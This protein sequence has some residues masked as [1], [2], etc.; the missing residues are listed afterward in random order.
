M[1][2]LLAGLTL[3]LA[4]LFGGAIAACAPVGNTEVDNVE[5]LIG[6][7]GDVAD[8]TLDSKDA[9]EDARAA[10]NALHDADKT[11]VENVAVLEAAEAEYAILVEIDAIQP[12]ITS[13]VTMQTGGTY[14]PTLENYAYQDVQTSIEWTVGDVGNSGAKVRNG[15]ITAD[16]VG[17][18]TLVATVS[19]DGHN[20]ENQAAVS[21][22]VNGYALSGEVIFPAENGDLVDDVRVESL[23]GI[24]GTVDAEGNFEIG[25]PA[26]DTTLIFSAPAFEDVTVSVE[27]VNADRTISDVNFADYAFSTEIPF[28]AADGTRLNVSESSAQDCTVAIGRVD[29]N[30][31]GAAAFADAESTQVFMQAT[32]SNIQQGNEGNCFDIGLAPILSS[33]FSAAYELRQYYVTQSKSY[34]S[35]IASLQA[36]SGNDYYNWR[37]GWDAGL[38]DAGQ[39]KI[40][41][42]DTNGEWMGEK[43][44]TPSE[45]NVFPGITVTLTVVR[46]GNKIYLWTQLDGESSIYHGCDVLK[47]QYADLE[48]GFG[49]FSRAGT[50]ATFSDVKFST[51][52]EIVENYI[53][54]QVELDAKGTDYGIVTLT[55]AAGDSVTS[56]RLGEELTLTVTPSTAETG[57]INYIS[58][59]TLNNE[60]IRSLM[61]QEDDS[62]VYTFVVKDEEITI[63]AEIKQANL[64][65]VNGTVTVPEENENLL[66]GL[67]VTS[68]TGASAQLSAEGTFSMSVP[69]NISATLSVTVPGFDTVTL[70]KSFTSNDKTANFNIGT[71]KYAF[72]QWFLSWSAT[73]SVSNGSV[74]ANRHTADATNSYM[75]T[76]VTSDV[77]MIEATI[78]NI[79]TRDG[80]DE[81]TKAPF[82]H[83][84]V[85]LG[86][87][88]EDGGTKYILAYEARESGYIA[89]LCDPTNPW[90][91]LNGKDNPV[92]GISQ[93]GSAVSKPDSNG[94]FSGLTIKMRMVRDE[95]GDVYL[96]VD[97]TFLGKTEDAKQF[98]GTNAVSIGVFTRAGTG[99]TFLDIKF[100][101]DPEKV[102]SYTKGTV[103]LEAQTDD[104]ANG[105]VEL[106]ATSVTLGEEVTLTIKPAPNT[107][108]ELYA[109]TTLTVG[110]DNIDL[111]DCTPIEGGYTYT[112]T[113]TKNITVNVTISKTVKATVTGT[114]KYPADNQN[115][116]FEGTVSA[117]GVSSVAIDADGSF[118]IIVPT[119]TTQLVFTLPGFEKTHSVSL[120]EGTNSLGEIPLTTQDYAFEWGYISGAP[121][122]ENWSANGNSVT[123]AYKEADAH[124]GVVFKDLSA[125]DFMIEAKIS[126]ISQGY[127]DGTTQNSFDVGFTMLF[128]D[129]SFSV[130]LRQNG[131]V[132]QVLHRSNLYMWWNG[133]AAGEVLFGK[134]G[135]AQTPSEGVFSTEV[136]FRLARY[137]DVIYLWANDVFLG[138][139]NIGTAFSHEGNNHPGFADQAC[140]FGLYTRGGTPATFS[141]ISFSTD[142]SVVQEAIEGL[143]HITG[144]V[145]VPEQNENLLVS[146]QVKAA[147]A[148]GAS[149][150]VNIAAGGGYVIAVPETVTVTQLTISLPGFVNKTATVTDTSAETVTYTNADYS[151]RSSGACTWEYNGSTVTMKEETD[152]GVKAAYVTS[153]GMNGSNNLT[154]SVFM[155]SAT[156]SAYHSCVPDSAANAYPSMIYGFR[157]DDNHSML[158][159]FNGNSKTEGAVKGN[160]RILLLKHGNGWNNDPLFA[161]ATVRANTELVDALYA[162]ATED[163]SVDLRMARVNNMLYLWV[164]EW[165][166]GSVDVSGGN[167][168]IGSTPG[169]FGPAARAYSCQT[170]TNISF[171]TDASIVNAYIAENATNPL[172]Q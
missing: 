29:A 162:P 84:D 156:V 25:V 52:P 42:P 28:W 169:C 46:D 77:F 117:S 2:K 137:N 135:T 153:N 44:G 166:V 43:H 1:K 114:L 125:T 55:N 154:A 150:S 129:T 172:F 17:T 122:N 128:G 50:G 108:T 20:I 116:P 58:S 9:I 60:D 121:V 115:L 59:V 163:G 107:A 168:N 170:Y 120:S 22:T 126:G 167:W 78:S 104:N 12:R 48:A 91:W 30:S 24:R 81:G 134:W 34:L 41:F 164:N 85:G 103:T 96:W 36:V 66:E 33:E 18:F 93:W 101:T 127:F 143:T 35:G 94:L 69:E 118:E 13:G 38:T 89:R 144:T 161:D 88:Y 148:D 70:V 105:T 47:E 61:T 133:A 71:E 40:P 75:L 65:T 3:C 37:N 45:N 68:S 76:G 39:T 74:T 31:F 90:A 146:G 106:S 82:S 92:P 54:K 56:A 123:V 147:A 79:Y 27:G 80:V 10:Y 158:I 112:F 49:L 136:T 157:F 64:I 99:A 140:Q 14:T 152:D 138:S 72:E 32:I 130:E 11:K 62:L 151:Y 16:G 155:I 109:I 110:G 87:G 159:Q 6:R 23:S 98:V 111:E 26:G 139:E 160:A 149:Y 7:I 131:D 165:F 95:D 73:G 57:K 21:V 15:I 171:T 63:S 142:E 19:Y 145:E 97:D 86:M 83:F 8:I 132:A 119:E 4:L 67:T 51:D 100:T 124:A 53:T 102:E 113:V 141:D 5:T